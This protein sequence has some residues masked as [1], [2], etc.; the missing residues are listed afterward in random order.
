MSFYVYEDQEYVHTA[1]VHRASCPQCPVAGLPQLSKETLEPPQEG[2]LGPYADR[3]E[4]AR[5][6]V[7]RGVAAINFCH[8]C[9]P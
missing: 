9:S 6:A 4:A 1:N 8:A 7:Q 2:W 5:A 3:E